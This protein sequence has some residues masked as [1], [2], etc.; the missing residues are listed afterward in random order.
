MTN[1]KFRMIALAALFLSVM[2]V[3]AAAFFPSVNG[4]AAPT[5]GIADEHPSVYTVR[6]FGDKIGIFVSDSETPIKIISVDPKSLP[7]EAQ[8]LL[9]K[10]ITVN[11][12]EEL[13][14]L[15]EDYIS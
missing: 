1:V 4:D 2:F 13:L 6:S 10:G 9:S 5:S 7:E 8:L 3:F 12:N 15:I 11:G 14:L